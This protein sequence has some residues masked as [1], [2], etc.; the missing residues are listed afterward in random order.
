MVA[1]PSGL[2]RWIKA[3]V[4]SEARV[5][6]PPLPIIL[7]ENDNHSFS[8][9]ACYRKKVECL[10]LGTSL[11]IGVRSNPHRCQVSFVKLPKPCPSPRE[12]ILVGA[13]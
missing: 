2:R 12:I 8:N 10:V 5:R 6:I 4:S 11:F 1:W 3:P 9:K 13:I 7:F